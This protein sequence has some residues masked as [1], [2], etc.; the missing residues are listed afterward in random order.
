LG[1][2]TE[3][4]DGQFAVSSLRTRSGDEDAYGEIV[5]QFQDMAVAYGY[6]MLRDFRQKTELKTPF[7]KR[8][9]ASQS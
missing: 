8:I 6:V 4:I 3:L 2:Y 5:R 1:L 7:W 9:A